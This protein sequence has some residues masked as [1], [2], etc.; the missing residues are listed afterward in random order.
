MTATAHDRWRTLGWPLGG[1]IA[2]VALC[3]LAWLAATRWP[4]LLRRTPPAS[5]VA[6]PHDEHAE[7]EVDRVIISPLA[8]MNIGL[9]LGQVER[10]D[11]DR[12]ITLPAIVAEQPGR[13]HIV[14][15]THF[16]GIVT[17]LH[18][19]QGQAVTVGQPLFDLRLTHEEVIQSQTEL[20]KIAQE[21]E[22]LD[23]EI[24]RIQQLV[25]EGGIANKT[26]LDRKYE[27]ERHAA[28][29]VAQKQALLL[30]EMNEEQITKVLKTKE[31]LGSLT[32]TALADEGM[33]ADPEQ[34]VLLVHELRVT[35]GQ[36]IAAGDTLAVLSDHSRLQVE[37]EAFE[38]DAP[39]LARAMRE[40]WPIKLL[41]ATGEPAEEVQLLYI[42]DTID[43]ESR[44]FHFYALLPNR[45]VHDAQGSD[46]RRYV[47]WKHR[48]GERLRVLAPVERWP[49]RLVVP[50]SAIAQDGVETYVFRYS[51][52]EFVRT[53]VHIEHKDEQFAVLADGPAIREGQV[54]ALTAAQQVQFALANQAGSGVDPHAGHTH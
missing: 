14:V 11:F 28:N 48:P 35:L 22:I 50:L 21:M 10:R 44:T 54:I 19:T 2:V 23:R 13:S 5:P 26:L 36:H 39:A 27:R 33:I 47:Q 24:A 45:L 29:F 41:A 18:I 20:L 37:G 16:T 38:Q 31:L 49:K 12:S 6:A 15:T 52:G 51:G 9:E 40:S 17:K 4:D 25:A 30:H 32:I 46:G 34:A 53:G 42:D 3:G 43:P 7:A 8:Q 1:L